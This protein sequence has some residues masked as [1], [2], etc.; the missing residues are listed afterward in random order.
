M[1]TTTLYKAPLP[2]YLIVLKQDRGL[3][4]MAPLRE[5]ACNEPQAQALL[6]EATLGESRSGSETVLGPNQPQA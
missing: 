3:P 1:Q 4:G 2:G 6:H 5:K